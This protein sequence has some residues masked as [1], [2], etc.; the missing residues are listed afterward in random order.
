V[1]DEIANRQLTLT[2][3]STGNQTVA[4]SSQL[5]QRLRPAGIDGF[6]LDRL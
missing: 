3:G 1:C 5:A 2:Y 6:R 4:D